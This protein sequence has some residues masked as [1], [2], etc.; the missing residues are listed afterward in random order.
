MNRILDI[1]GHEYKGVWRLWKVASLGLFLAFVLLLNDIAK[2]IRSYCG[3][4]S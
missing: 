3:R 4:W 2:N 1:P